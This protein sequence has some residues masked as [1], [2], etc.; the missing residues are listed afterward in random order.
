M[1]LKEA[2][3]I[4]G[5]G[6]KTTYPSGAAARYVREI[7]R[8]VVE[9]LDWYLAEHAPQD[10]SHILVCS[11]PYDQYRG[12][13]QAPPCVVHYFPDEEAPGFYLSRGIVQ[14][15]YNDE[16]VTFTHWRRLGE[17]PSTVAPADRGG[18]Q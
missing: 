14:N 2:K 17:T 13:D 8:L 1:S 9:D 10:G 12:F 7:M 16:P 4:V 5:H 11:G 15:S 3:Q 6:D 18:E